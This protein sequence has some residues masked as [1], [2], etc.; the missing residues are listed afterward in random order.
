MSTTE[1]TLHSLE[2]TARTQIKRLPQRGD[3]DHN[4]IYQI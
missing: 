1:E 3:Y 2:I 4:T